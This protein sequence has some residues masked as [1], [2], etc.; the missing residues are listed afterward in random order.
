MKIKPLPTNV[1][2]K[3]LDEPTIAEELKIKV[4][5]EKKIKEVKAPKVKEPKPQVVEVPVAPVEVVEKPKRGR[6]RPKLSPEQLAANKAAAQAKRKEDRQRVSAGF[7]EARAEAK[8]RKAEERQ[9]LKDEARA[10][11][12][13]KEV[14]PKKPVYK[15]AQPP[16]FYDQYRR[17]K[18]AWDNYVLTRNRNNSGIQTFSGGEVFRFD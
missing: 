3:I 13:P 4:P 18:V 5:K 2:Q 11:A 7:A 10:N 17:D 1:A 15:D 8:K 14:I 12:P 16:E 6:G 9:R